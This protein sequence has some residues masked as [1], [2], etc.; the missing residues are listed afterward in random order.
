[1]V[2]YDETEGLGNS[3][4]YKIELSDL[5]FT[6]I[7]KTEFDLS[8]ET[9][10]VTY[11]LDTCPYP[12]FTKGSD[13]CVED[14]SISDS[15]GDAYTC[16]WY[17]KH[18]SAHSGNENCDGTWDDDDFVSTEACCVCGGG[19]IVSLETDD[20]IP[21]GAIMAYSAETVPDEYLECDGTE[22]S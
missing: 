16:S 13:F 17:T 6:Y 22:Y 8:E 5:S 7:A 12:T 20:F 9:E 11:T 15:G 3:S 4:V 19:I 2:T 18:A 1:L 14:L 10:I 21:A